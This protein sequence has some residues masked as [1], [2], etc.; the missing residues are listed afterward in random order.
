MSGGLHLGSRYFNC[1][2]QSFLL[3][4]AV[5]SFV[6]TVS[7]T[8][9]LYRPFLPLSNLWLYVYRPV[10]VCV[11]LPVSLS[12]SGSLYLFLSLAFSTPV[13]VCLPPFLSI[14]LV[15]WLVGFSTSSSTTRLYRGR[16]PRQSV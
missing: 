6:S 9:I 12:V 10:Y 1:L 3:L 5:S 4:F 8:L 14:F 7:F 11:C 2:Y 16:A 15:G 13:S